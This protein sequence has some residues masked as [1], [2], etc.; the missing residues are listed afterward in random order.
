V[1]D[2]A[3]SATDSMYDKERI[4]RRLLT[5]KLSV[6]ITHGV[7]TLAAHQAQSSP[8]WDSKVS[9]SVPPVTT[10]PDGTYQIGDE[11]TTGAW[12]SVCAMCLLPSVEQREF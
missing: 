8:E 4:N 5:A 3:R 11:E 1:T 7:P 2:R 12:R 10:S 6:C 9:S